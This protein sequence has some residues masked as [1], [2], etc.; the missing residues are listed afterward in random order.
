MTDDQMDARLRRAGEA[1]RAAPANTTLAEPAVEPMD[2]VVHKRVRHAGRSGLLL[3]VAA[4]AA[5]LV[6]GIAVVI[7]VF[8][9]RSNAPAATDPAVLTNRTWHLLTVSGQPT[10]QDLTL[11]IDKNSHIGGRTSGHMTGDDGCHTIWTWVDVHAGSFVAQDGL[12][13]PADIHDLAAC[14]TTAHRVLSAKPVLWSVHGAKL[15]ITSPR[16]PG[17]TLVYGTAAP[18]NV[19]STLVGSTWTESTMS[20]SGAANAIDSSG[21]YA[22]VAQVR[23]DG[24]GGITITHRCYVNQGSVSIAKDTLTIT[25]VTLKST[26]PCP[27]TNEQTAEQQANGIVDRAL[28][29]TVKWSIDG[30]LHLTHG[31]TT[32]DFAR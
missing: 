28:S 13:L 15:T 9:N 7:T 1:W 3:S 19:D 18:A 5:A 26:V 8:V 21:P 6:A 17:Q 23:L 2:I 10:T 14:V 30:E 20:S 12:Q 29:G 16:V 27:D 24:H 25:H 32:I 4:V 22:F 11:R 31:G